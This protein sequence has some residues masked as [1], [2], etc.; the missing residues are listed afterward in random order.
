MAPPFLFAWLP[1]LFCLVLSLQDVQGERTLGMEMH[2][3][4]NYFGYL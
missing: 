4:L 2:G 3:F 1:L